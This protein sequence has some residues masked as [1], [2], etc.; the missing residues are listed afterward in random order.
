MSRSRNPLTETVQQ[1]IVAYVRAG[2]F[3]HVAA[4]AAGVPI[5]VFDDWMA[6]PEKRYR[7]FA[8]A[9]RQAQAQARLRT[10]ITLLDNRPLDWLRCGP[11]KPR[12]GY[13]GWTAPARAAAI[14]GEEAPLLLNRNVQM[15]LGKLI[16]AMESHP[17]V[18]ARITAIA[19]EFAAQC[20]LNRP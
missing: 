15:L 5:E 1:A 4:E 12:P 20:L 9:V 18:R 17:E 14:A 16:A 13:P 7:D 2:G 3:S 11:G 6:R 8:Q 10:E 19:N